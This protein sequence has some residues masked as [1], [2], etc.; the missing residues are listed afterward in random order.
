MIDAP[1]L[2]SAPQMAAALADGRLTARDLAAHFL[3][4]IARF[5]PALNAITAI[6]PGAMADAEA[7]DRRRQSGTALGPLDGVPVT[8]K[9]SL[10]VA[11]LP[12]TWGSPLFRDFVAPHDEVTVAA[13]RAAGAVILGK[14]NCPEFAMRG[15]TINP[16]YGATANPWDVGKTP[17]GSSGGAVAAVAA[18]LCPLALATDGGGSIRRPAAHTGLVGLKPS[19]GRVPRGQGFPETMADCEVIGAIARDVAGAKLVFDAIARPASAPPAAKP[20][21]I[22]FV[23]NIDHAPVDGAILRSCRAAAGRLGELGHEVSLGL[24]PF[25]I[26]PA[27]AAWSALGMIGLAR[28]AAQQP[29]F[30]DLAAADFVEQ[31]RQGVGLMQEEAKYLQALQALRAGA[32]EFFAGTDLIMTPATAAQPWPTSEIYPPMIAGQPV[33]PRG[34][35]IFT[36][37]V[38]C[39]GLPAIALPA[40]PAADEMPIGFQLVGPAGADDLLLAVAAQYEAAQPFAP[41]WPPGFA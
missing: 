31:A 21:R 7:S 36:A 14:T 8:V 1:H 2:L 18:G 34:H 38:N 40:E 22:R 41:R 26:A 20:C 19:I 32:A 37:W 4:R 24:L 15:A 27:L 13:L 23:E 25:D 29:D 30:F 6:N 11:G 5:N 35:A 3:E 39:A 12:A 28:L 9:D 17:G 33:G 16:V 10:W